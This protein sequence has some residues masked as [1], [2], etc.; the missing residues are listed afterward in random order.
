MKEK[1][2]SNQLHEL[3]EG[4]KRFNYYHCVLLIA[5]LAW[6]ALSG[7]ESTSAGSAGAAA[8]A[9]AVQGGG[10]LIVRRSPTMGSNLVLDVSVDGALMGS[11]S[12]GQTF[13]RSLAPG[14]HVVSVLLRPNGLNL[15]PTKK[16][17]TIAKGHTYALNAEWRGETLVLR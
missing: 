10:Q 9:P 15:Q 2:L 12:E 17:I 8:A 4:M 3:I 14:T 6:A 13:Q 7:C 5:T 16:T 1:T 11:V